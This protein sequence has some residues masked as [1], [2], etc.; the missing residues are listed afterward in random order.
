MKTEPA[1]F[2]IDD[3]KKR[4]IAPWDGVRNYQARNF[5]QAMREGDGV[6]VYHSSCSPPGVAGIGEVVREAY[7]DRSAWDRTSDY[8]DPK[9]T[10]QKPVWFMVDVKFNEK[11]RR[12]VSLPELRAAAALRGLW[13]LKKGRLSVQPVEKIHFELVRRM[14]RT[15]V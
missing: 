14:G 5:M 6:L 4:G 15:S 9:S 1:E 3:L 8:Y 11:F 12:F 13:V 10:P 2:S 7:P